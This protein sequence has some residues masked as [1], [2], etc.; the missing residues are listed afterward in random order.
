MRFIVIVIRNAF[1][2]IEFRTEREFELPTFGIPLV[3]L[4]TAPKEVYVKESIKF[5][6][7]ADRQRYIGVECAPSRPLPE[8]QIVQRFPLKFSRPKAGGLWDHRHTK[9]NLQQL[10]SGLPHPQDLY[11]SSQTRHCLAYWNGNHKCRS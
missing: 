6:L 5:G 1:W 7:A 4:A 11:L 2:E 8:I 9:V 3:P 10:H